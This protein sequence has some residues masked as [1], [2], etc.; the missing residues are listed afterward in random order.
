M[1]GRDPTHQ[2][3]LISALSIPDTDA[4]AQLMRSMLTETPGGR[5]SARAALEDD[6]FRSRGLECSDTVPS[7][8]LKPDSESHLGE[9]DLL[10]LLVEEASE[11]ME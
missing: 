7:P 3:Q 2:L 10:G 11:P 1:P 9:A 5:V 4:A 8:S 6:Y